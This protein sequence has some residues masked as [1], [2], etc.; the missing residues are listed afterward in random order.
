[1]ESK[2]TDRAGTDTFGNREILVPHCNE[3]KYMHTNYNSNSDGRI[4]AKWKLQ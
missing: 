1:M 2:P 3:I 4:K